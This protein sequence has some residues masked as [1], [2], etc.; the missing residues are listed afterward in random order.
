MKRVEIQQLQCP[1]RTSRSGR[2]RK[3]NA[4]SRSTLISFVP[5]ELRM[6][7]TTFSFRKWD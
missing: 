6:G 5:A 4:P 2:N 3:T 7:F 1:R